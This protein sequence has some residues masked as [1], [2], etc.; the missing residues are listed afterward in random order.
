MVYRADGRTSS[1]PREITT[2]GERNILEIEQGLTK[3][4]NILSYAP[5]SKRK[6]LEVEVVLD[7][8]DPASVRRQEELSK[9]LKEIFRHVILGEALY[10]IRSK[11]ISNGG[12]LLSV[13]TN[14]ISLLLVQTAVPIKHLVF[15]IT[16]GVSQTERDTYLV[17]LTHEEEKSLAH[18]IV[19][20][21][22]VRHRHPISL[23]QFKNE[24]SVRQHRI[25]LDRALMA[26]QGVGEGLDYKPALTTTH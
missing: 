3:V 17:D 25:L 9:T 12:S 2:E 10:T 1:Q 22:H 26:V 20:V 14:G 8:T 4:Q 24:V 23:L 5:N 16:V 15:S 19:A 21:P 18:V 7:T 6:G 11:V 13:L